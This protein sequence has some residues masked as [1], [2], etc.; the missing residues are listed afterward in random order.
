MAD[1]TAALAALNAQVAQDGSLVSSAV[2]ALNGLTKQVADLAAQLAA[3]GVPQ[4]VV[5]QVQALADQ[6][7]ANNAALAAAIPASTPAAPGV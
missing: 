4:A 7:T 2:T 1:A 3:Q 6:M 5:D